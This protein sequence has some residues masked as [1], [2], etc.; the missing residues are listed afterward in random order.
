M[1]R[2]TS[3]VEIEKMKIQKA[4]ELKQNPFTKEIN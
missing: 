1:E 4:S 2:L 3:N